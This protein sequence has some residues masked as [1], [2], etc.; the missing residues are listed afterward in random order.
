MSDGRGYEG[1]VIL[2]PPR[3]GTTLLRRLVDA[4]PNLSCPPEPTSSR[5]ARAS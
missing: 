3:S 4:H 1:A 5:P 2:G